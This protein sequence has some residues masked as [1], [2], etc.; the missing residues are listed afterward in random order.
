MFS[1]HKNKENKENIK[2]TF[3]SHL[4]FALKNTENNTKFKEYKHFSENNKMAFAVFSKIV[5]TNNF[6]KQKPN[7]LLGI[8]F[9]WIFFCQRWPLVF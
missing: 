8:I 7:M 2:N 3:D 1:V 6:Q 5:F 9:C 4:F